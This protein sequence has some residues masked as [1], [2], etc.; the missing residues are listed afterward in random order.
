MLGPVRMWGVHM[1]ICAC[2]CVVC[3]VV[4]VSAVCVWCMHACNVPSYVHECVCVY[5]CVCVFYLCSIFPHFLAF[6]QQLAAVAGQC[7]G[8][9]IQEGQQARHF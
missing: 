4:C 9:L 7:L 5:V 2:V 3:V 6:P 8:V 1:H